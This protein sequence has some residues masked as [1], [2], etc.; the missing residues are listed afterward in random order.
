MMILGI[1]VL[2]LLLVVPLIICVA[3]VILHKR[4]G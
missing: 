2:S 3:I 4:G 1:V